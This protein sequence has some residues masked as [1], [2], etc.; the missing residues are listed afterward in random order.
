M[1]PRGPHVGDP[2]RWI[3]HSKTFK[4]KL[5]NKELYAALSFSDVDW[6]FGQEKGW[7]FVGCGVCEQSWL[8][9][10]GEKPTIFFGQ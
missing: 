1:H 6:S 4:K 3:H 7:K 10:I 9:A 5:E 8:E 2:G